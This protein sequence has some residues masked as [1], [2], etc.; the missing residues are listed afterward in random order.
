MIMRG[1]RLVDKYGAR[2]MKEVAEAK[3]LAGELGYEIADTALQILGGIGYT[4]KYPIEMY[5][6]FIRLGRIA[7]GTS[8]IM[9]YI[10]QRDTFKEAM[11]RKEAVS[12]AAQ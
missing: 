1:A 10:V 7:S 8:E 5:L 12:G 9:K 11:G 3:Y 6:R 4:N 2:A